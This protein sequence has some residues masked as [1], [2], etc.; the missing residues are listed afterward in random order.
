[1]E[2]WLLKRMDTI[3][4]TITKLGP[5]LMTITKRKIVMERGI[6]PTLECLSN[7]NHDEG[8]L[9]TITIVCTT[10]GGKNISFFSIKKDKLLISTIEN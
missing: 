9:H 5:H 10:Q 7:E 6:K 2:D 3:K 8:L 4:I 1:M